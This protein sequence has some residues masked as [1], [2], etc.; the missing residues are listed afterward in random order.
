MGREAPRNVAS[1][2]RAENAARHSVEGR[3]GSG[4]RVRSQWVVPVSEVVNTGAAEALN[5]AGAAPVFATERGSEWCEARNARALLGRFMV[6][7]VCG[8]REGWEGWGGQPTP[9][10]TRKRPSVGTEVV[11]EECPL[12]D[13]TAIKSHSY[14]AY[15]LS[16][17]ST[18]AILVP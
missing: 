16:T 5:Y 12:G 7:E 4:W 6:A 10:N 1:N 11:D 18:R 2:R 15:A 8:A 3:G 14:V 17:F 9:Q 13:S